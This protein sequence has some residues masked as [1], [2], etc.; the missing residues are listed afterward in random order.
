MIMEAKLCTGNE[1]K[2]KLKYP[3]PDDSD[4]K[5]MALTCFVIQL[6]GIRARIC[7]PFK[8]TRNRFPVWQNWFLGPLNVYKYGLF[9][10][11][12]GCWDGPWIIY[13]YSTY[14]LLS[15]T[16]WTNDIKRT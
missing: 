8:E 14:S 9:W 1:E 16:T 5:K 6:G 4:V 2:Q 12:I 11:S 10:V 15:W 3:F 7:K 13:E